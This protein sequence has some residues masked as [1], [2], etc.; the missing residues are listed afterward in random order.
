MPDLV[1]F[2]TDMD[3][4][5]EE[6]AFTSFEQALDDWDISDRERAAVLTTV[7]KTIHNEERIDSMLMA[8][9]NM[10]NSVRGQ[11]IMD[12]LT[13]GTPEAQAMMNEQIELYTD[14]NVDSAKAVAEWVKNNPDDEWDEEFYGGANASN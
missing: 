1:D 14:F 3:P 12:I 11:A 4:E 7:M 5:I 6:D 10:R 9:N 8:L 2:M 13:S